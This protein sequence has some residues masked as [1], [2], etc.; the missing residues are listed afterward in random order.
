MIFRLCVHSHLSATSLGAG[1]CQPGFLESFCFI[2]ACH[3][4]VLSVLLIFLKPQTR[5]LDVIAQCHAIVTN[6]LAESTGFSQVLS[7]LLASHDF[8]LELLPSRLL[9]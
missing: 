6:L 5:S 4:L 2:A 8:G 3:W 9:H 7:I 1:I